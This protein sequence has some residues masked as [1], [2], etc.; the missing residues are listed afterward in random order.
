MET[1]S[2]KILSINTINSKEEGSKFQKSIIIIRATKC[3]DIF[4]E[5]ETENMGDEESIKS[6][7]KSND[8][9]HQMEKITSD[10]FKYRNKKDEYIEYP[11]FKIQNTY[12]YIPTLNE[13]SQ[14][15]NKKQL[16]EI[17]AHLPYY[18]Q[19]KNMSLLYSISIHGTFMRTF[20]EKTSIVDNTVMIIKDNNENI[21]GA[22]SS[23]RFK[24]KYN[25]FYGTAETFLFTFFKGNKIHCFPS[26][27]LKDNFIYSDDQRI[28]F[29][30]SDNAF[31]LSLENDF[32]QGYTNYTKT[33]NN[34]PLSN[35][36]FIVLQLEV[37][38]FQ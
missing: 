36:K 5:I 1:I 4:E 19:Y 37:W 16:R 12:K 17:H 21:F 3:K 29:G 2:N 6:I 26:S 15:V 32:L 25:Q 8:Y 23:E 20:Y 31:S 11:Y 10:I 35:E 34:I 13:K 22:Y 28:A 18:H 30:C 7:T 27:H 9:Q 24:I 14:I 38:Q 33:F